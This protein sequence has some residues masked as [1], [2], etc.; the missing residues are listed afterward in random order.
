MGIPPAIGGGSRVGDA[1]RSDSGRV[2]RRGELSAAAFGNVEK[3]RLFRLQ[4][5]SPCRKLV[6]FPFSALIVQIGSVQLFAQIAEDALTL[7]EIEARGA[8]S[9]AHVFLS[10]RVSGQ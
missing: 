10:A 6:T 5:R 3:V 9:G 7:L 2:F 1:R 8:E 4:S